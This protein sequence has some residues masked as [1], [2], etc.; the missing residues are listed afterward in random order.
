MKRKN[1]L[2]FWWLT[3]VL[4]ALMKNLK[5]FC[6]YMNDFQP[7]FLK[8]SYQEKTKIFFKY[9]KNFLMYLILY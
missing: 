3:F 7:F 5:L 2:T 8:Y 6:F 1:A 9:T 4:S